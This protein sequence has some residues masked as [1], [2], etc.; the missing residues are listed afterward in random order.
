MYP[1]DLK[2]VPIVNYK[3]RRFAGNH[4]W[5]EGSRQG[6]SDERQGHEDIGALFNE[7]SVDHEDIAAAMDEEGE[8]EDVSVGTARE[9]NQGHRG[10]RDAAM[11]GNVPAGYVKLC[12][13][14][15]ESCL[16]TNRNPKWATTCYAHVWHLLNTSTGEDLDF[17]VSSLP[18]SVRY[19]W[20]HKNA[21]LPDVVQMKMLPK[22]G[23]NKC[24][25]PAFFDVTHLR[26]HMK[27]RLQGSDIR[28]RDLI[29]LLGKHY[30][31]NIMCPFGCALFPDEDALLVGY[32]HLYAGRLKRD[33]K[34]FGAKMS[35]FVGAYPNWPCKATF[36]DEPV[37][38][39]LYISKEGG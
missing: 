31:A 32:Q 19:W 1:L 6:E 12:C 24:V 33:Y 4:D 8:D 9:V 21:S 23:A 2:N 14:C 30:M 29:N 37:A 36:M 3:C 18:W 15:R 38:A 26:N 7:E 25:E 35:T 17:I 13:A 28:G 16:K 10:R 34:H 20:H 27:E 39:G 22:T 5:N 11:V